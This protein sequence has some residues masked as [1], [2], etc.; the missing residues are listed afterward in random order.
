[1]DYV[2]LMFYCKK[3]RFLKVNNINNVNEKIF[4]TNIQLNQRLKIVLK[5]N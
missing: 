4:T 3:Y 2:L 5:N 1:M